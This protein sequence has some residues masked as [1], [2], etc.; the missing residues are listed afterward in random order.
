[1]DK[2]LP[3]VLTH[4][5]MR[6]RSRANM[7]P[8][9]ILFG[10]PPSLGV[11]PVSRP[12]PSTGLCEDDMLQYCKNLSSTLSQISQQVKSALPPPASISLHDFQPGDWVVIKDLRRKHWHSKRW[13]GPF[14]VLLTT[15]TAVKIAERTTWIHASHCRKVPEPTEGLSCQPK[16]HENEQREDNTRDN[17]VNSTNTN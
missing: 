3:I 5:R 9:E 14:Q 1:M 17:S 15:H 4:M 16:R 12:L 7:S 8:F 11:E 2:G 13:R 10:R 6:K